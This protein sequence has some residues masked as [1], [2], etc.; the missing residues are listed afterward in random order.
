MTPNIRNSDPFL[1]IVNDGAVYAYVMDRPTGPAFSRL[2][3]FLTAKVHSVMRELGRVSG[4]YP[5]CDV[6]E[7]VSELM[8]HYRERF[9]EERHHA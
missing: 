3:Y 5:A 2:E 4:Y 7:V 8:S 9:A 6:E 1:S